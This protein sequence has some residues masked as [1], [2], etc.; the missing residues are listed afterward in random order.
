MHIEHITR[1]STSHAITTVSNLAS[2]E[3]HQFLK[4]YTKVL[5]TGLLTASAVKQ[6]YT[7]AD[8]DVKLASIVTQI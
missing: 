8:A 7:T 3:L 4:M 2:T 5:I 6:G 1:H